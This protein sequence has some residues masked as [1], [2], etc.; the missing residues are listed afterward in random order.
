M[1]NILKKIRLY[2]KKL[3]WRHMNKHNDTHIY[4]NF[5]LDNVI[6]GKYTYG[7]LRMFFYSQ[8]AK[9]KIGNY[10]SI[11]ANTEFLV[12]GEHDYERISTFPFQTRIYHK[13][14][15]K[16]KNRD[17][18]VEDDVW[19]GFESLIMSG[20]HIGQG[21]VI[22]ARSVVTGDVPPYSIYIGNRVVKKRFPDN[23]IEKLEHIN[24]SEVSHS[25]KDS[26]S[27]LC[28]EKINNNN[29]DI[30]LNEFIKK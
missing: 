17:I 10:C 22:G 13:K 30:I 16:E 4:N 8:N 23:I 5:P 26:Y 2:Y 3:K 12:G 14:G 28:Q 15:N 19:I 29:V 11:A 18:V 27:D 7:E 21:C 25:L 20:A 1:K 24:Y 9:V 6:V